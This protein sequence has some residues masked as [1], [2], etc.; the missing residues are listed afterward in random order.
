M[1]S[2]NNIS[3]V[4]DSIP[5]AHQLLIQLIDEKGNAQHI[6]TSEYECLYG[7]NKSQLLIEMRNLCDDN[8]STL[9]ITSPPNCSLLHALR[10][11]HTHAID[12]Q[13]CDLLVWARN[14]QYLMV[15]SLIDKL[16]S[17]AI[18]RFNAKTTMNLWHACAI[19][20]LFV[21]PSQKKV[22][23]ARV[24]TS[25]KSFSI[26]VITDPVLYECGHLF[27]T[28]REISELT[29]KVIENELSSKLADLKLQQAQ[30]TYHDE[31]LSKKCLKD[32]EVKQTELAKEHSDKHAMINKLLSP[33]YT[34]K[35]HS[36]TLLLTSLLYNKRITYKRTGSHVVKSEVVADVTQEEMKIMTDTELV[37]ETLAGMT[38]LKIVIAV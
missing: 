25:L 5:Q 34:H 4:D 32:L 16:K 18:E 9:S 23:L 31:V 1:E 28:P 38:D 15:D 20:S 2:L 22:L 24:Y 8:Y 26:A 21:E 7:P 3:L 36:R 12:N 14:A 10:F 19:V 6:I 11:M 13:A 37:I 35:N 30:A 17:M 27:F 33:F 29:V